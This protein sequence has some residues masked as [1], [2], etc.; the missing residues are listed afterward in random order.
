[1]LASE[2]DKVLIS[3][4]KDLKGDLA[5]FFSIRKPAHLP[6]ALYFGQEFQNVDCCSRHTNIT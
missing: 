4:V 3:F 6:Q 5:Q 1:M 2:R